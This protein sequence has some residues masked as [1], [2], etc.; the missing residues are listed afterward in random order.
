M[1]SMRHVFSSV[2]VGF[3]FL[4]VS[5]VAFAQVP[6]QFVP[7]TP[8]RV[9]DTRLAPGAFGGPALQ[10]QTSRDF[11]IPGERLRHSQYGGGVFAECGRGSTWWSGLS[12]GVASGPNAAGAGD[13]EF[14]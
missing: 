1:H 5:L 6:L 12:D 8:C 14:C 11:A 2:V 13:V 3:T 10:G 9:A 7:V 4:A